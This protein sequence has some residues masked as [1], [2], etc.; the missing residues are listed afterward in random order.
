LIADIVCED[1]AENIPLKP[2]DTVGRFDTLLYVRFDISTTYRGDE[3]MST[4]MTSPGTAEFSR[5]FG[6]LAA[7]K[8]TAE[9]EQVLLSELQADNR[10]A[11]ARAEAKRRR[12]FARSIVIEG[13]RWV[14]VAVET[15]EITDETAHNGFLVKMAELGWMARLSLKNIY[16]AEE[17]ASVMV[18]RDGRLGILNRKPF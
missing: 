18:G 9:F 7:A 12:D 17:K 6:R 4:A 14:V 1:C 16:R 11:A 8:T 13:T 10:A 2:L 3:K 15:F 5:F